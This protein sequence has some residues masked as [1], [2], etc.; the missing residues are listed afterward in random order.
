MV[1]LVV[2]EVSR[3]YWRNICCCFSMF[4]MFSM[5]PAGK[6]H[7]KV[8][9]SGIRADEARDPVNGGRWQAQA[10]EWRERSGSLVSGGAMG[11]AGWR[12]VL[13]ARRGDKQPD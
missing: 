2:M 5:F 6:E 13:W 3:V 12:S 1:V 7:S 11:L 9:K 8:E 10:S 4:L